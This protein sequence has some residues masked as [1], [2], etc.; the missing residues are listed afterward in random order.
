MRR[1]P[2]AESPNLWLLALRAEPGNW[3]T[4]DLFDCVHNAVLD[5]QR[6]M[7]GPQELPELGQYLPATFLLADAGDDQEDVA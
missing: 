5:A 1:P 7:V 4:G 2:G 3:T 6:R